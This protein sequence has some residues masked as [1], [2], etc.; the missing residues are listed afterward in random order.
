MNE[1]INLCD[2]LKGHEEEIF[3]S[4]VFGNL[5]LSHVFENT[6]IFTSCV[7]ERIIIS[8]NGK[9]YDTS[10]VIAVYPSKDLDDWNK[11]NKKSNN[12]SPKTWNELCLAEQVE[13]I[14]VATDFDCDD[15]N[16]IIDKSRAISFNLK[17]AKSALAFLKIHQLIKV[18]Y[19]GNVTNEEWENDDWKYVIGCHINDK[20]IPIISSLHDKRLIA[21]HTKEQVLDFLS[22]PENIK[23]IEDYYMID[24]LDGLF[25]KI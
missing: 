6:L 16:N 25:V 7:N 21:F 19:G 9:Y 13:E 5:T 24:N 12:K 4:P 10:D 3:Y 15:K 18:G 23:L 11:W 17:L 20:E 8:D 1:N 2:I 22:Y 14:I